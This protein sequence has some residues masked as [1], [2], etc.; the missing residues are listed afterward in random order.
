[1]EDLHQILSAEAVD[2]THVRVS[3]DT[4]A[5]GIFDCAP[6]MKDSY[7]SRLN[8]PAFF[9]QVRAECGMLCWPEDIDIAPE[10]V[11]DDAVRIVP[12][13]R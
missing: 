5:V 8:D 13:A 12:P 7:W 6:Y 10:D 1:M 11:W 2:G 4:G 9:R 3:F